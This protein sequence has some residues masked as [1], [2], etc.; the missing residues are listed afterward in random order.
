MRKAF[1]AVATAVALAVGVIGFS[2][3]ASATK[4]NPNHKVDVC[5]R[6]GSATNPYVFI[7]VDIASSG[8]VKGGH[9]NHEQVGNGLGGDIIAA[10][11]YTSK[12][13][14]VFNYPGKNLTTVIGGLTGAELLAN[15][16]NVP[17]ETPD[18]PIFEPAASLTDVTCKQ[19]T[20][21]A[22]LDN[23]ASEDGD[24]ADAD[25]TF[26]ISVNGSVVSSE[27]I[28]AGSAATVDVGPLSDGDTVE[29]S[30]D[31]KTLASTTADL[32]NCGRTLPPPPPDD[33]EPTP[34]GVTPPSPTELP[35]TL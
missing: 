26:D 27:T 9:N 7:N 24:E 30:V 16:C 17:D 19:L 4:P 33:N 15:G 31:G 12:N 13:G 14:D 6:T 10:Y 29:V 34:P 11:T 32:S 8:Y 18:E 23:S 21:T 1:I 5:H 25:V 2:G 3:I 22:T 35:E 20:V 28:A